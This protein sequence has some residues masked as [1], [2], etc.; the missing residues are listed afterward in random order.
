MARKKKNSD[1][2]Y[3]ID[4][5]DDV[6]KVELI[7]SSGRTYFKGSAN[8]NNKKNLQKL[9]TALYSKGV[10]LP[11]PIKKPIDEF[12]DTLGLEAM[13]NYLK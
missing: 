4:Y 1:Y 2:K 9:V 13:S 12:I 6:I 11:I 3:A 8:I 7:D 5:H 10:D